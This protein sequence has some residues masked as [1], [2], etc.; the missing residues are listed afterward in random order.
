MDTFTQGM[1]GAVAA[2]AALSRPLGRWAGVIGFA[3]GLAADA[4]VV[5]PHLVDVVQPFT[6]HR[7]FTH[8]L[9]AIPLGGVLAALPFL[10][11]RRLR[12]RARWVLLAGVIAYAT[13]PIL[14]AC[15]SF[16]THVLWPFTEGR[17]AWDCLPIVDP[18]FTLALIGASIWSGLRRR[19]RPAT[20]ALLLCTAYALLGVFQNHRALEV[21]QHL[22]AS[23]GHVIEDGRAMPQPL[24]L[25]LWRSV[26]RAEGRVHVDSLRLPLFAPAGVRPGG[27]TI[28]TSAARLLEEHHGA[29]ASAELR[30][31]LAIFEHFTDGYMGPIPDDPGLIADLRIS[32]G[33]GFAVLWGIRLTGD[34]GRPVAWARN[35][36]AVRDGDLERL[37]EQVVSSASFAGLPGV[38][39]DG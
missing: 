27:S 13:H 35:R 23:R 30:R 6:Y 17:T 22:A 1:L 21:Q 37:V 19:G 15:T 28:H 38:K 11:A 32:R 16:G 10:A 14:D 33:D 18:L 25:L 36:A 34:P 3:G 29:D 5:I 31:E 9:V 4:D 26:Y 39:R 7:H 8:A 20:L 2:Q 12:D 24:S